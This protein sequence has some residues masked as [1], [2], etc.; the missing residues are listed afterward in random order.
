MA[1]ATVFSTRTRSWELLNE[2]LKPHLE[3]MTHLQPLVTELQGLL[4]T[5]RALDQEQ[6]DLR[7]KLRDLVHRRQ[8]VERQGEAVRRR[9][10][11]HLRGTYGY[12]AEQLIKF[13]VKPRPRVIRRKKASEAPTTPEAPTDKASKKAQQPSASE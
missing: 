2:S 8:Q 12:T 4:E 9:V 1:R 7:S 13:G 3:E 10:E 6:E 11:A 5:G